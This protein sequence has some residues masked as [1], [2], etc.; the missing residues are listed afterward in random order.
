[1]VQTSEEILIPRQEKVLEL[2]NAS[3]HQ[4]ISD[5]AS[6]LEVSEQ[7]IRRDIKRLDEL[8]LLHRLH[9]GASALSGREVSKNSVNTPEI[10]QPQNR[11]LVV[12][13]NIH[14]REVSFVKEKQAIAR[15]IDEL[16]PEGASV[17]ITIGT[18]VEKIAQELSF[19]SD[20]TVITNSIRVAQLLYKND[21]IKVMLPSGTI[22]PNNGGIE[23]PE[24]IE[25]IR[26]F[27]ADYLVTSIGAIEK[28]GTLLD[29]NMT[30]TAMTRTMMHNSKACIV[31]CD[32][33]KFDSVAS[34]QLG[35]LR[36]VDFLVT[37]QMPPQ[38]IVDLLNTSHVKLI[39][40][41]VE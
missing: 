7:T 39:I 25:D 8:K 33:S 19:K 13:K 6:Q 26:G 11:G 16:I 2:V 36:D 1:M 18:T 29:F 17:F 34:I 23:G 24:T 27:R 38:S 9:G 37:D 41:N 22:T 30:E 35:N 28:D 15:A 32:H 14:E 5:L 3:G 20:L 31:A 21:K 10:L 40:A 4:S 12:N